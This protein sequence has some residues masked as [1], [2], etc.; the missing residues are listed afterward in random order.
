M[1]IKKAEG[2]AIRNRWTLIVMLLIAILWRISISLN[3]EISFWES[4]CS[5]IALFIAGWALFAYILLMSQGLKGWLVMNRIY[6]W[7]AV[8][9]VMINI[10]VFVYYAVRWHNIMGEP[11]ETLVPLD[12]LYR[13]IR[14]IALV[15][16][17]CTVLWLTKYLKKLHEEY[18]LIVKGV[19]KGETSITQNSG[20]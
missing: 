7:I 12:F 19:Q 8:S 15:A 14:Y 2:N 17:Y 9:L 1:S 3:G 10:Y 16:F 11:E 13:D 18:Q 5:G 6:S 20:V 4:I